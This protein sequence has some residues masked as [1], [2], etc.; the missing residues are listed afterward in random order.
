MQFHG[1]KRLCTGVFTALA[2]LLATGCATSAKIHSVYEQNTNF[3]QYKTFSFLSSL[4]PTGEE[5]YRT[6]EG[7]YLETAIRK[8]LTQ[9]GLVESEKGELLVGY[10]VVRTEKTETTPN[11]SSRVRYY[12]GLY[13]WGYGIGVDNEPHIQQYTEGT[14]TI[15]VVDA[16]QKQLVWQGI[17]VGRH[18]YPKDNQLQ[19]QVKD[20]VTAIFSRYPVS[21]PSSS[22]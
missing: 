22:E 21:L 10:D 12:R 8:E 7:K 2:V 15:D 18:K 13:G 14:L 20:K 9:R 4:E 5:E 6:L 1:I 17:A 11:A 16:E 3:Q 19:S